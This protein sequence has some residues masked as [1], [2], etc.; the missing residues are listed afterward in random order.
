MEDTVSLFSHI[1]T[2]LS[3]KE[4]FPTEDVCLKFGCSVRC[5]SKAIMI[6]VMFVTVICFPSQSEER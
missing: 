6:L 1:L 5:N 4:H 2:S 3:A